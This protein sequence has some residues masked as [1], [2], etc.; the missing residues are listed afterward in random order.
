M[1]LSEK[2]MEQLR[3]LHQNRSVVASSTPTTPTVQSTP[4]TQIPVQDQQGIL[5]KVGD[6]ASGLLY[7]LS[8][9]GRNMQKVIASGA[10]KIPGVSVN[11]DIVFGEEKQMDTTAKKAGE[12]VGEVAPYVVQPV[13]GV[14]K[15]AA[16]MVGRGAMDTA[17]GTA[18][19]GDVKEGA[20]IGAGGQA[21]RIGGKV[22]EQV[23]RGIYKQAIPLN[24]REAKAVQSYFAKNSPIKRFESLLKGENKAPIT[25]KETGFSQKL[26]GTETGIGVQAKRAA[27]KLWD[28]NIAPAL[29][30]VDAK[31][32]MNEFFNE[33]REKVVNEN[34]DPTRQRQLLKALDA[35][36]EDFDGV[37]IVSAGKLQKYK[38]GWAKFVPQKAYKGEDIAGALNDLRNSLASQARTKIYELVDDPNIKRAY[39]DYGNLKGLQEW[40]QKAMT[41]GKLRGGSG[42]FISA[43]KDAVVTPVA[44][45]GGR[46]VYRVGEGVEFIAPAGAKT[47]KDIF[48]NSDEE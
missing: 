35:V 9:P 11:E 24:A 40:G 26:K 14:V 32:D 6:F 19:T 45:I 7:G 5:G 47:L 8:A 10:E 20:M 25:A 12:F 13:K 27:S 18:Q 4:D 15:G 36:V 21:L 48:Y 33:A 23:G 1:A 44:T 43:I 34:V 3:T 29:K 39:I 28:K 22:L 30:Q 2:Q 17:I 31:V 46:T 37:D 41:G 38:E 16:G 42:T